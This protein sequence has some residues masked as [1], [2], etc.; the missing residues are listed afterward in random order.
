MSVSERAVSSNDVEAGIEAML[1]LLKKP[2]PARRSTPPSRKAIRIA[3]RDDATD[4]DIAPLSKT[5]RRILTG[6][7]ITVLVGMAVCLCAAACSIV[8]G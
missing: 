3:A 5:T 1:E 4:P 8:A 7:A 2:L 6:V